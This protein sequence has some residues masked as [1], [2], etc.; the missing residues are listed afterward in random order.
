LNLFIDT[1][2]LSKVIRGR[3][4]TYRKGWAQ[5]I[6]DGHTL[7]TSVIVYFELEFGAI[8]SDMPHVTRAKF[9]RTVSQVSKIHE[10]TIP[11][12]EIAA[13]LR[14][15]LGRRGLPIGEYDLL[16]AAQALRLG[17]PIVTNNRKHF[18]RVSGLQVVDWA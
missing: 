5:A 7:H 1:N 13:E 18:D 9:M 2:V 6:K 12:V 4:M 8:K 17:Y 10:I 11:D 14:L 3:P 15:H 16:I